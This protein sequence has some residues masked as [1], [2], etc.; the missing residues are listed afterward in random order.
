MSGVDL[1]PE[2]YGDEMSLTDEAL[3]VAREAVDLC[4]QFLEDT[5]QAEAVCRYLRGDNENLRGEVERLEQ[6]MTLMRATQE[7]A[8]DFTEMRKVRT[9]R[10]FWTG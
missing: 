9:N 7:W 3:A 5:E 2:E 4:G 10:E 6:Q 1:I 8:D